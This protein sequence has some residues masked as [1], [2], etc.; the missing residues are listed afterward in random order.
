MLA[1]L[2]EFEGD[3][4]EGKGIIYFSNGDYFE[5]MF[6]RDAVT[7]PGV[8]HSHNGNVFKGVWKTNKLVRLEY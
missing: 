6:H 7:G 1:N 4:K 3:L 8:F 2:G 5:G